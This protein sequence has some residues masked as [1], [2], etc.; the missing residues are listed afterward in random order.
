M[1]WQV[2]VE[3]SPL[4]MNCASLQWEPFQSPSTRAWGTHTHSLIHSLSHPLS[5]VFWEFFIFKKNFLKYSWFTTLC[6]FLLYRKVTQSDIYIHS[7]SYIIFHHG[8]FWEFL[9]YCR[10]VPAKD[11]GIAFILLRLV[12]ST[13]FRYSLCWGHFLGPFLLWYFDVCFLISPPSPLTPT[14]HHGLEKHQPGGASLVQWTS[15]LVG[16]G[17]HLCWKLHSAP[18]VER[19]NQIPSGEWGKGRLL[20]RPYFPAASI[21]FCLTINIQSKIVFSHEAQWSLR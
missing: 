7:L 12:S 18:N 15:G 19:E 2:Q 5:L 14:H 4:H 20:E 8:L 11:I 9:I 21:A 3:K 1:K 13:G 17:V 10:Q 6:Q 16:S